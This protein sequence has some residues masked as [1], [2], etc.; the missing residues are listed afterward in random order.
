M[1]SGKGAVVH[2]VEVAPFSKSPLPG[3]GTLSYFSSER[4]VPGT[5]VRADVRNAPTPAVVLSSRSVRD[6]KAEIRRAGFA[7]RKIRKADVTAATLG[8]AGLEALRETARYYAAPVGLLAA[9]LVPKLFLKEAAAFLR[10]DTLRKRRPLE[11]AARETLL[12][13]MENE[14][15]FG[16]YRALV[17]QSF[18]RNASI[19]FVVPTHLDARRVEDELSRG[20]SEFA[21]TLT[22]GASTKELAKNWQAA[23][24]NPHPVL[25]IATPSCVLVPRADIDTVVVE[26]ANSR[27]YRLLSRPYADLRLFVEKLAR[28]KEWR[29]VM[30]DSVL[31]IEVLSRIKGVSGDALT[32]ISEL[33]LIRWRLLAAPSR[34]V[35]A[36]TAQDGEGRFEIFSQELKEMIQQALTA[37]GKDSAPGRVF[38]FGARKGLAPTTVCGDCGTVLPCRNCGAPVVLHKRGEDTVYICHACG[39]TRESLT[40]CG[41]CGNWRLVPLG[42]GIEEV[43]R[44]AKLLFPGARVLVLDKDRA[45]TDAKAQAIVAEFESHGGILVGTE[46]AFYHMGKV[47][48]AAAVS[49]DALFSLPDFHA[50]ERI[51]YLVSRLREAAT[52]ESLIQTRRGTAGNQVLLWAAQGLVSEFYQHEMRERESLAYPPFSVFVKIEAESREAAS[53]IEERFAAWHPDLYRNS[54]IIRVPR[55]AWPDE[56]LARKLALLG[57]AFS[58]KVDPETLL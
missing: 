21:Y 44:Q 41:V 47:P 39:A 36:S 20:V 19:L 23:A 29:L 4:L 33:S 43:S 52:E 57:G 17:R 7:L 51:F 56:E 6:A 35:D 31:P 26:R 40:A 11:E 8:A 14:E 37:S 58:V 27:A 38:L 46:L 5:I 53:A 15:R 30:G 12:L 18:A 1:N 32:P 49:L 10:P 24:E 55:G 48:Y 16:Q 2:A 9:A 3:G 50:S 25:I 54:L 42:I 45:P 22:L 34:V 28:H 13:Q